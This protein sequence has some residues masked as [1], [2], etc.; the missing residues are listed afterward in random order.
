MLWDRSSG[1]RSP[2]GTGDLSLFLKVQTESGVYA[3]TCTQ[4]TG[5]LSRV[6]AV[7]A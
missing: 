5:T 1:V 7:G 2:L 3:A 6:K 4:G